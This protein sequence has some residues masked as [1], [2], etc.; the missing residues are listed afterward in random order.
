MSDLSKENEP[1]DATRVLAL[2]QNEG[3]IGLHLSDF[4]FRSEQQEMVKNIVEAYNNNSVALIEAGTGTGKSMAYL[5]PAILWAI[6]RNEATLISTNTINL[7]EQLLHKDIPLLAKALNIP[8]KAVLVK[9]MGNYVCLRKVHETQMEM[10]LFPS[11]EQ[12]QLQKI[13]AWANSTKDGSKSDLPFIPDGATWE[14]VSAENDLC[15]REKCEYYSKCHFFNARKTAKDAHIM[16]SNHSLL[17]SDLAFRSTSERGSGILPDYT[18]VI[19]DEAH[20]IEDIATDHF[21]SKANGLS[22]ARI[23]YRLQAEKLGKV[24][25]KLPNIHRLLVRA[26]GLE[27]SKDVESIYTKLNME[28]PGLRKELNRITGDVFSGFAEFIHVILPGDEI[29]D[30]EIPGVKENKLRI[31]PRHY[32]HPSWQD[33]IVNETKELIELIEKFIQTLAGLIGDI[34]NLKNEKL[35]EECEPI[36]GEITALSNRLSGIANT[37]RNFINPEIPGDKVRWVEKTTFRSQEHVEL[38][39]AKLDVSKLLVDHLFCK[40]PTTVLC[41]ATLT[42]NNQFNFI[43]DRLGLIPSLMQGKPVKENVYNSPFNYPKQ[44]ILM[45]PTDLPDPSSP[46]FLQEAIK[47]IFIAIQASRGNAFVLFTSYSMMR[48]CRDLMEKRL[49]DLNFPLLMQGQS[50]RKE[51]IHRFIHTDRSVLFG[52][53][54]FWEGVDVAGEALRCVII[55]KLPFQVP[56]EPII[57]AR[58]ESVFDKGGNPFL[59]YSIPNA[60]V[61]FKQGFGRLIRKKNDRGCIIC[62]DSRLI[63]KNYGKLFLNSLPNCSK[64]FTDSTELYKI[65]NDF[66]RKTY[67]LTG[68]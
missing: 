30:H 2:F 53:D 12:E 28:I 29:P 46:T 27:G 48:K 67:Y 15:N 7:Q 19:I 47:T 64:F 11:E 65:M 32:L 13:E 49:A 14:K 9:G 43:K 55:V 1:L 51:L 61:K 22:I 37:L 33:E 17:F 41:S 50:T 8:V 44:A 36:F 24:F 40:F 66:Y 57:Q 60:I 56:K 6:Q 54:S 4:E 10:T 23:L 38:I 34:K 26:Y 20:N 45:I 58:M 31:L 62:L 68:K 21:A 3:R 25:G 63:K 5:V 42:T 35:S 39:D 52:T 16:I 18:K 59:D